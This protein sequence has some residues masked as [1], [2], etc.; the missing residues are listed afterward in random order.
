VTSYAHT[1][2][3]LY[4]RLMFIPVAAIVSAAV[5]SYAESAPLVMVAILSVLLV[6]LALVIVIFSSLTV[7]V[8]GGTLGVAFTYGIMRRTLPLADLARAE[9]TQLPWYYGAGVKWEGAWD[10]AGARSILTYLAWPGDAVALTFRDG[11]RLQIGTDDPEGLLRAV[12]SP[13]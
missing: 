1:Q 10:K 6:L 7:V 4:A 13:S 2:T 8:Q 11:R 9:R 12:S 3:S 5:L